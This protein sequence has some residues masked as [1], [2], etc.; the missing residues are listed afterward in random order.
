MPSRQSRSKEIAEPPSSMIRSLSTSSISSNEASGSMSS[1]SWRSKAPS[2]AVA[3]AWRQMFSVKFTCSSSSSARRRRSSSSSCWRSGSSP[4]PVCSQTW[5]LAKCSS[6]RTASPSS[7]W[8][9]SRRWQPADSSRSIASRHISSANSRKSAT[10][11]AYSRLWLSSSPSPSTRRSLQNSSR[12]ARMSSIASR[13]PSASRVIPQRSSITCA[14]PAVE[15]ARRGRAA[16][17]HQLVDPLLVASRPV[18]GEGGV[19][20]V[21]SSSS[22]GQVVGD[23]VGEDEVAV[24]EAL[25]H[26]AGAEPVGAVVGEVASPIA[27]RPGIVVCSS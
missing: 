15:D 6:S 4:S 14:E 25:H 1:T 21:D 7:V 19:V 9:S 22:A 17:R 20:G 26:R 12:I 5:T 8:C 3:R 23:G 16:D 27:N 2:L 11:P 10:R 13:R 24:G 18:L